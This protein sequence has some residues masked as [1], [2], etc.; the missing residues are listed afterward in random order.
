[1]QKRITFR[2]MEHTPVLDSYIEKQLA[3]VEEF[4][5]YERDPV[6]LEVVLEPHDLR[7]HH[8]TSVLIKSPRYDVYVEKFGPDMYQVISTAIDDAYEMLRKQKEKYVHD[9]KQGVQHS[10]EVPELLAHKYDDLP[11]EEEI[12]KDLEEDEE[13]E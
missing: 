2:H 10:G 9:E 8:R 11:T 6:A 5:S 13:S 4:L 12:N 1:M 7:A 3:K